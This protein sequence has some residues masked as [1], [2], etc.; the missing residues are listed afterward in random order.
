MYIWGEN[1]SVK[2][3]TLGQ[4]GGEPPEHFIIN[5][6]ASKSLLFPTTA[7]T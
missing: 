4:G 2:R 6:S 7:A 3:T 5:K 1:L